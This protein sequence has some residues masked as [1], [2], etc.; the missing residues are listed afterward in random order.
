M[1]RRNFTDEY[2]LEAVALTQEPGVTQTQVARELGLNVNLLG[3]WV[4]EFRKLGAA[5]FPGKGK[6]RDAEFAAL[7]RELNR[8]KKERDFLREAATYFAKES[9]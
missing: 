6:A 2:K 4:R 3:R 9:K 5:A 7:R 1:P 8:V